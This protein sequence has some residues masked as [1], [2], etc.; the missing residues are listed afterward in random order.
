MARRDLRPPL[1][2]EGKGHRELNDSRI[3][4]VLR[5]YCIVVSID[6]ELDGLFPGMNEV[7]HAA[8][9]RHGPFFAI[10]D[11]ISRDVRRRTHRPAIANMV[12]D[13]RVQQEGV[14]SV[15][16]VAAAVESPDVVDHGAKDPRAFVLFTTAADGPEPHLLTPTIELDAG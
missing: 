12:A 13:E 15:P 6:R 4:V 3:V 7:T 16:V 14:G 8:A 10:R 11:P 2:A 1:I 5:P 9:D